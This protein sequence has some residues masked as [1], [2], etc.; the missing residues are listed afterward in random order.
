MGFVEA[1]RSVLSNGVTF[2]GRA[3]RSEYWYWMLFYL[4][5]TI[6]A[7]VLDFGLLMEDA[8]EWSESAGIVERLITLI[9]AIP[10]L[11]VSVRRL[12]DIDRSGWW[13]LLSFVPLVGWLVLLI[14][15]VKKGDA[16]DNRFGPPHPVMQR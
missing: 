2:S 5:V 12:H 1:I 16:V 15:N 11:A 8:E 3:P 14:W 13:V 10:S 4:I 7:A 9:L 6:L